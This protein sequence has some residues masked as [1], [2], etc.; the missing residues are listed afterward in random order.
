MAI[1]MKQLKN[2]LEYSHKKITEIGGYSELTIL[3]GLDKSQIES[4]EQ[5]F[6]RKYSDRKFN[7]DSNLKKI[8]KITSGFIWK[9]SV[10]I[11][12]YDE[13]FGFSQLYPLSSLYESD[14]EIGVKAHMTGVWRTMI[15][16]GSVSKIAIRFDE[17][18]HE[19][20]LGWNAG[21]E[22]PFVE[23]LAIDL[24]DMFEL[25]IASCGLSNWQSHFTLEGLREFD[26]EH[27]DFLVALRHLEPA[28]KPDVVQNALDRLRTQ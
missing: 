8:Y 24:S 2:S 4:D 1:D 15:D 23:P 27:D 22:R 16:C 21:N 3:D 26:I 12:H 10:K 14:E 28:T 20:E 11:A 6:G 5:Y 17:S 7:F 18:E 9:W 19:I 13:L 25:L